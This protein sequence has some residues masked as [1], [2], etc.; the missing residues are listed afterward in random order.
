MSYQDTIYRRAI[1]QRVLVDKVDSLEGELADA[2]NTIALLKQDLE[3]EVGAASRAEGRARAAKLDGISAR[4]ALALARENIQG[5]QAAVTKDAGLYQL[6]INDPGYTTAVRADLAKQIGLH[7]MEHGFI[8]F[9]VT[10]HALSG[11]VAT[12][13]YASVEKISQ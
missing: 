11:S 8:K 6:C 1:L 2:N 10:P 3:F 13:A 12:I 7:M 9:V 4:A 5:I